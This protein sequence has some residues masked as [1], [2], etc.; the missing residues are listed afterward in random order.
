MT[1]KKGVKTRWFA[2]LKWFAGLF[3]N[4]KTSKGHANEIIVGLCKCKGQW[5]Q[6]IS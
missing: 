2:L 3:L 5:Y 6:E 4:R 1:S